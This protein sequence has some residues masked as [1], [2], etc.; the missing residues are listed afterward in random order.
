M[1]ELAVAESIVA[2]VDDTAAGRRV[3]RITVE[4]GTASCVSAE[5]LT[6]CLGLVAEGTAAQG[7]PFDIVTVAGERLNLKSMEVEEAT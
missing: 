6:F 2:M 3:R 7:A 4:I 1:H 5:A